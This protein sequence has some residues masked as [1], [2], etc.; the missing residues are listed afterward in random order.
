M[1]LAK[2]YA[3]LGLFALLAL[4]FYWHA[5]L[6]PANLGQPWLL[7]AAYSIP[8]IPSL[9]GLIRRRPNAVFWGSI[10]ALLYF[11]HGIAEAWS[12]SQARPL[13]L[14]EAGLSAWIVV[15]GSWDGMRARLSKRKTSAPDV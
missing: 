5:W 3:A 8:L 2:R 12:D 1:S 15:A 11:C 9:I 13:A 10:A 4:Q 7:P 14:L 6:L